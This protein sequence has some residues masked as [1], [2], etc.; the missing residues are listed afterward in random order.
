MSWQT[1]GALAC[2]AWAVAHFTR[3]LAREL[4]PR[5]QAGCGGCDRGGCPLGA[6]RR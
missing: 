2:L 3:E 6:P 4:A 5:A 1:L